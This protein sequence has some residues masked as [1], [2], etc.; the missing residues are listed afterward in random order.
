MTV[1]VISSTVYLSSAS[2]L[3]VGHIV[4][5]WVYISCSLEC[6]KK[7]LEALTEICHDSDGGMYYYH[8]II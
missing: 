8:S 6:G 1:F 4:M 2:R 7:V 5:L 3:L